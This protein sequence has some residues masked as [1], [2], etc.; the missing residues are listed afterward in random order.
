MPTVAIQLKEI[1]MAKFDVQTFLAELHM[2][3]IKNNQKGTFAMTYPIAEKPD[4]MAMKII[5]YLKQMGKAEEVEED[6][7][8]GNYRVINMINEERTHERLGSF[9]AIMHEK[10]RVMK[11]KKDH[12]AYMKNFHELNMAQLQL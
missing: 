7:V 10:G 4:E 2:T 3:Y 5:N 1:K 8:L 6:D 12:T 11:R 9:L